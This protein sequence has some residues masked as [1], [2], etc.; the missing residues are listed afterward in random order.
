M[1]KKNFYCFLLVTSSLL[2]GA[3]SIAATKVPTEVRDYPYCEVIP[4]TVSGS[5]MTENFFNTLGFDTCPARL[6]STITQK[7][8][9]DAYTS[10]YGVTPISATINGRRH[11]VMDNITSTGGITSSSDTLTV[12]GVEF[13]LKAQSTS[14]VGV[15][16]MGNPYVVNTINRNTIYLFKKG[17]LIYELTDPIGNV[18]VMQ[19]YSQQIDKSLTLKKLPYIGPKDQL[20]L[21]WKYKARTLKSDLKLTASGVTQIVADHFLNMFQINPNNS[22]CSR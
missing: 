19:S 16:T 2:S 1:F 15:D 7:A 21:G 8:I 22:K 20:P 13:G 17:R 3:V 12:N 14:A 10:A 9:I 6:W 5:T 4:N 18:Y 11:W